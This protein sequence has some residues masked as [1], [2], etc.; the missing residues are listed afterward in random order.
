MATSAADSELQDQAFSERRL[1]LLILENKDG[2]ALSAGI[3]H[4][5]AAIA[6][7]RRLGWSNR[8]AEVNL[9][10]ARLQRKA[11]NAHEGAAIAGEAFHAFAGSGDERAID[12][13]VLAGGALLDLNRAGEALALL[14]RTA[15]I[16]DE[17]NDH[18]RLAAVR[19]ELARAHI[20]VG[21][22][23]AA[24]ATGRLARDTFDSF[25]RRIEVAR[26]HE[27]FASAHTVAGDPAAAIADYEAAI[28]ILAE[29]GRPV[30]A[31]EVLGRL[32]DWQRDR[33]DLAAAHEVLGRA[34]ALYRQ[35]GKS[36]L[37]AQ[38]LRRL[39]TVQA[40]RGDG[41]AADASYREALDLCRALGDHEGISRTLYLLG[42]AELR[43]GR[44]DEG[45][46]RLEQSLAAAGEAGTPLLR[47]PVLAAIV[48]VHRGRGD[49]DRAIAAMHAW[50]D[51]LKAQGD[52]QDALQ[53]LG[54]IAEVYQD[55]G[56]WA[57][58]EAHLA[59]LVRVTTKAEDRDLHARALRQLAVAEARRHDWEAARSH[60]QE[61]LEAM[62]EATPET[63]AALLAQLGHVGLREADALARSG[64]PAPAALLDAVT[65]LEEAERIYRTAGDDT[66]LGRVLVDLGNAKALLGRDAE[67]KVD[68]ERA[69]DAAEKRGDVRAT[70]IIRRATLKL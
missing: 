57:D 1:G 31:G 4:F 49:H 55:M 8:V 58:A 36:P 51:V 41:A 33:G 65:V 61:A 45:L 29:L 32:A 18:L 70:Q 66:A 24:L 3:P 46:A 11:G 62:V 35:T 22:A 56:A 23:A 34:L 63:R 38:T 19:L 68:F 13:G 27:L 17:R 16:A 64:R 42:A 50:V 14:Q 2:V 12:A 7:W 25:R 6:I 67:A 37:I 47:E 44:T 48:R 26:C 59:R 52:R 15:A 60:L 21:D 5:Q 40:K 39:G 69:A 9:D 10:L 43:A 20:A 54:S 30:D 53:V 28:A